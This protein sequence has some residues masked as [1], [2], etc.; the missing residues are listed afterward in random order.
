VDE[1]DPMKLARAF[2]VVLRPTTLS[3]AMFLLVSAACTTTT[4]GSPTDAPSAPPRIGGTIVFSRWAQTGNAVYRLDLATGDEQQIRLVEDGA[5]LSPDGSRFLTAWKTPDG[6]IGPQTFDVDGSNFALL[7]IPDPTLQLGDVRWSPD[8]TRVLAGGWD[9][10]D[11]SRGGLYTFRSTDG[12]GLVRLTAP[13]DP[14]HDYGVG[15]SPDGSKVLFIREVEPY[16]HSGPMNVFVVGSDGSGAVRLNAPGTTSGLEAQSWSP[17]GRQVAFVATRGLWSFVDDEPTAV[18]VVDADGGTARRV[19]PWGITMR[20]AWSPDGEWIAYDF[21]SSTSSPRDLFVVHPDG[22]ERMNITSSDDGYWEWAPVWSPD[23]S[24]LLF[25]R[26]TPDGGAHNLWTVNVD[27]T[28]IHQVTDG[29]TDAEY[30]VYR[31]LPSAA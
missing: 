19:T 25:V 30:G 3:V 13:G 29:P 27:G 18:F 2:W 5:G 24:G 1:E 11:P 4:E 8:G 9:D 10:T 31:W 12:G 28:D 26:F 7:P 23:S 21:A 20:A 22:T 14:P 17:D 6:R 15:Y 16:D